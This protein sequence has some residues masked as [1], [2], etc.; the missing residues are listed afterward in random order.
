MGAV[1]SL[2]GINLQ[3]FI[4][5]IQKEYAVKCFISCA[6]RNSAGT[7]FFLDWNSCSIINLLL[8]LK[9]GAANAA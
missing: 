7:I 2:V 3:F 4:G 5:L 9:K 8:N 6:L 1:A